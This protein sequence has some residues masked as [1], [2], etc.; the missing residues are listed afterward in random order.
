MTPPA[1]Y[2]VII[3]SPPLIESPHQRRRSSRW[4]KHG[5][6]SKM[7]LWRNITSVMSPLS[8]T[9][10][11]GATTVVDTYDDEGGEE[12]ELGSA[13]GILEIHH[14]LIICVLISD[15]ACTGL[16]T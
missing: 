10:D 7:T 8:P 9:H 13:W 4:I 16:Q 11:E 6:N 3:F 1:H 5:E 15:S 14:H 2:A 12:F